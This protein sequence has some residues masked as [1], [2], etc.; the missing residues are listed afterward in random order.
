MGLGP[1]PLPKMGR[2]E[3][4]VRCGRCVLGCPYGAKWDSRVFLRDAVERGARLLT[5]CRAVALRIAGGRV[6]G[7]DALRGGLR[8]FVAADLVVLAA[9]GLGT[10]AVLQQSGIPCEPRLFVDPVLCVAARREGSLLNREISMPFAVQREGYI[11][12]PY[13]DYL[14]YFFNRS[15][16]APAADTLSLMIKLA[17]APGGAIER[18]RVRKGL[19]EADRERLESGVDLC[20]A[21]L[22]RLGIPRERIYLGTL[23]AG[24]PGGMLPLGP[25]DARSLHPG[26]LPRNLYVADATLLPQSLGNPPILTIMAL[27]R[28]VAGAAREAIA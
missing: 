8:T 22:G 18:G 28:R 9:G 26:R 2:H 24:H 23:N 21:I 10:P 25:G 4:C 16:R 20:A 13:F 11:V 1:M 12:S 15:W 5:R 19:G 27:A 6:T 17:D 14:S 3:S 7:V